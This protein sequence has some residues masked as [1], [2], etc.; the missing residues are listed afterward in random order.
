MVLILAD[1][2]T[3]F[4]ETAEWLQYG[5]ITL[6]TYCNKWKWSGGTKVSCIL[7]HRCV[8]LILAYSWARPAILLLDKGI[9]L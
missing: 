4:S 9:V 1:D 7:R 2:I 5:L 6:N 8:Q 3:L